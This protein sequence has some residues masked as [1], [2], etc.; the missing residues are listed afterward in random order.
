M[1]LP[2]YA[3]AEFDM[4]NIVVANLFLKYESMLQLIS[5]SKSHSTPEIK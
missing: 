5:S 4:Y 3:S 2:H 1:N